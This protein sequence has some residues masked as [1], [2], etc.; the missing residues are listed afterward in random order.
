MTSRAAGNG[1]KR[2]NGQIQR[3]GEEHCVGAVDLAAQVKKTVGAADAER[4]HAEQRQAHARDEKPQNGLPN[5]GTGHLAEVHGE[6]K[7]TCAEKQAEEHAGNIGV[8]LGGE[9][10][11]HGKKFPFMAVGQKCPVLNDSGNKKPVCSRALTL[12]GDTPMLVEHSTSALPGQWSIPDP[13]C[14]SLQAANQTEPWKM[15]SIKP[16]PTALTT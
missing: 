3:A 5:V 4:G 14:R 13:C 12:Q 1:E 9:L 16:L 6:N 7:V 15:R 2:P 11:F 8:F 10:A